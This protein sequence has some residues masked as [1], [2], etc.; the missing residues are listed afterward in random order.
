MH[1]DIG[2]KFCWLLPFEDQTHDTPIGNE[3]WNQLRN[4]A[5]AAK[6][7]FL[8]L[9]GF[10]KA[11]RNCEMGVW[12]ADWHSCAKGVFRS[13]ENFR[14]GWLWG[15]KIISQWRAIFAAIP[16]FRS[17]H[18]V[19]AKSFHSRWPISQGPLLGCKISQTSEFFLLL[20][21]FWLP[22]TF[23]YFLCNSS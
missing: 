17:G 4:G 12:V 22:E 8:R 11:F 3:S 18:F 23:L 13:C 10:H 14:R 19:A 21:S 1:G 5:W 7:G 16:W 2:Y 9:W 15:Y 20:S 6:M